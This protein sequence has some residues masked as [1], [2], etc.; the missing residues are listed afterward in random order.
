[1]PHLPGC[2]LSCFKYIETC[3]EQMLCPRITSLE[4]PHLHLQLAYV[5]HR[6]G[7][8][9]VVIVG[10]S[11]EAAS[12]LL[13]GDATFRQVLYRPCAPN[14]VLRDPGGDTGGVEVFTFKDFHVDQVGSL[15]WG[16]RN[17]ICSLSP[18]LPPKPQHC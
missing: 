13:V 8:I 10:H 16:V 1:M 15:M 18:R 12:P 6:P 5:I 17:S 14:S 7:L 3:E 9:V 11:A 4:L 2:M